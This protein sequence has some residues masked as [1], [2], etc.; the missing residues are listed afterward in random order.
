MGQKSADDIVDDLTR[1]IYDSGV[2]GHYKVTI[3]SCVPG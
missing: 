2:K 1:N 3:H